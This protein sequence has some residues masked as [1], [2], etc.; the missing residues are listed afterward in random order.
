MSQFLDRHVC[1]ISGK[2]ELCIN[3]IGIVCV[4]AHVIR[5]TVIASCF[6]ASPKKWSTG[7]YRLTVY[8]LVVYSG[9]LVCQKCSASNI[10]YE[11]VLYT[12]R[13][14]NVAPKVLC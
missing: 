9:L 7:D 5:C 10:A 3:S 2:K 12:G 14:K 6:F 1:T 8:S 13:V 4:I 11:V